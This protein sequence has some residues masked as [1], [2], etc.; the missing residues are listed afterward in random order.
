MNKSPWEVS[1]RYVNHTGRKTSGFEILRG[2]TVVI[3]NENNRQKICWKQKRGCKICSARLHESE[4]LEKW[5]AC[6]STLLCERN[7]HIGKQLQLYL[8]KVSLCFENTGTL[9]IEIIQT[10]GERSIQLTLPRE[11]NQDISLIVWTQGLRN[12][13]I[14]IF[15][16]KRNFIEQ[17]S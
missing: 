11:E 16:S 5:Y 10:A 12:T 2:F 13:T 14:Y 4:K 15:A 7:R 9:M 8:T 6:R 1:Q 3:P 17:R